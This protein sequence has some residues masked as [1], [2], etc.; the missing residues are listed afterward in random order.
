MSRGKGVEEAER[1]SQQAKF[2]AQPER[3]TGAM[4]F[5]ELQ[6]TEESDC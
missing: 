3:Q 2:P 5:S 4:K 1:K 6:Q